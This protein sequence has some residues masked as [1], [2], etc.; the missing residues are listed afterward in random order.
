LALSGVLK[1]E[2]AAQV[3]VIVHRAFA[4]ME[5][6]AFAAVKHRL[7][8]LASEARGRRP[9]RSRIVDAAREGWTFE[10]LWADTRHSKKQLARHMADCMALGLIDVPLPGAP[11]QAALQLP[12]AMG[13]EGGAA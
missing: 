8:R 5:Q 4:A 11:M 9:I 7:D 13:Q 6:Q 12:L 2:R 3:S 1:T 10:Q